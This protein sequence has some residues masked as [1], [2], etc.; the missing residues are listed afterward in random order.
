MIIKNHVKTS[1]QTLIYH[2]KT[3]KQA[4]SLLILL[5]LRNTPFEKWGRFDQSFFLVWGRFD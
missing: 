4:F 5:Y 2:Y 3:L 1:F